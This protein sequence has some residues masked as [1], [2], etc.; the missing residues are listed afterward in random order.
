MIKRTY[1]PSSC[2]ACCSLDPETDE[3]AARRAVPA[4]TNERRSIVG[5]RASIAWGQ[6]FFKGG[7]CG[8]RTHALLV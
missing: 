2:G 5:V 8:R 7:D 6:V 3:G 4:P 1:L